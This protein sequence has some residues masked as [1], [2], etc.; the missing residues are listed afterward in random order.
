[1]IYADTDFFLALFK[2]ED[3]LKSNANKIHKEYKGKI[4]TSIVTLIELALIEKK[5]NLDLE[6]IIA[7]IFELSNVQGLTIEEGMEI[8][9][10]IKDENVGVF[11]S[12][13]AVLS[14]GK[15]IVSS[16]RVYDRLGK[17][18]IKLESK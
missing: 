12:F 8:A 7:S 17:T 15:T 1:M 2:K 4:E 14:S 6:I 18:R 16:E 11:D 10:L 5:F 13:H 9:H 3:W